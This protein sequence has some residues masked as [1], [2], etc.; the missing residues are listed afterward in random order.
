MPVS[1]VGKGWNFHKCQNGTKTHP[2][3]YVIY[4]KLQVAW[5]GW[6]RSTGIRKE[7]KARKTDEKIWKVF[8][9][10]VKGGKD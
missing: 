5:N 4:E 6:D 9:L 1:R 10:A 3:G 7:K 2:T 8:Q